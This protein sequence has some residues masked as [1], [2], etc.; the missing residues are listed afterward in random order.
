[1]VFSFNH[2]FIVL[3]S[4]W[5]LEL[6]LWTKPSFS[7]KKK[8]SKRLFSPPHEAAAYFMD[9]LAVEE[10]RGL[11]CNKHCLFC[12]LLLVMGYWRCVTERG[13]SEMAQCWK[14]NAYADWH[15]LGSWA[16]SHKQWAKWIEPFLAD[17]DSWIG[18]FTF[19]T[20]LLLK[21]ELCPWRDL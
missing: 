13:A 15:A 6:V 4:S 12:L 2:L 16:W 21:Q 7:F 8:H 9:R 14:L 11:L 10:V 5:I 18:C 3:P 1:M 20:R 17:K 19:D